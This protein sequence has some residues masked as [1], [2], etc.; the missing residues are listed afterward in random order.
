MGTQFTHNDTLQISRK[1]G[2]P[3]ELVY[4]KHL[5]KPLRA[6]DFKSKVFAFHDKVGLRVYQA[7]RN[8]LLENRDEKYIYWGLVQILELHLDYRKK[9]V[10]GTYKILYINTP[11]EMKQA[12][13]L[14]DRREGMDFFKK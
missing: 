14:I 11:E 9:V 3:K 1:Q 4:E 6:K 12:Y 5:K 10:S 8:F 7:G 2:F 13:Q